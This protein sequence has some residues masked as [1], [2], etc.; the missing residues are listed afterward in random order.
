[1]VLVNN[2]LQAIGNFKV[3]LLQGFEDLGRSVDG[4]VGIMNQRD[5]ECVSCVG[6]AGD[7]GCD[8]GGQEGEQDGHEDRRVRGP[9]HV[10]RCAETS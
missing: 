3:V 4:S 10:G 1:M 8:N 9:H 6:V 5:G 7:G 2:L